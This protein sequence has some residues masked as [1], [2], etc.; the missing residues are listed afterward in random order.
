MICHTHKTHD[1]I[2]ATTAIAVQRLA[3]EI[4]NLKRYVLPEEYSFAMDIE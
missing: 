1:I 4:G 2:I 3:W